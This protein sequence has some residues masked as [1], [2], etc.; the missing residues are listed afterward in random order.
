VDLAAP[1]EQIYSTFNSSDSAYFPPSFITTAGTSY[2]AAMVSGAFALMLAKYPTENYQ[3][4]IARVLAATD[5]LP[6]L[7]GK[8]VTGGRLNLRNAL[9]PP[10]LLSPISGAT[11]GPFILRL[12]GGPNRDCVIQRT[13]DLQNWFPVFTNTTST[14]GT[15]DYTDPLPPAAAPHFF[16]GVSTL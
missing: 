12:S 11:N 7:A 5:P 6:A 16:R 13:F 3:Q 1:G 10:I 14:N 15:F 9:S 2:S 8:C 4:V